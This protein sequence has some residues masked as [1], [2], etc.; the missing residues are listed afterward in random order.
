LFF[1]FPLKRLSTSFLTDLIKSF[2]CIIIWSNHNSMHRAFLFDEIIELLTPMSLREAMF[3][4]ILLSLQCSFI[5]NLN[6]LIWSSI[7]NQ[8]NLIYLWLLINLLKQDLYSLVTPSTLSLCS[9]DEIFEVIRGILKTCRL[10]DFFVRTIIIFVCYY[11]DF[12]RHN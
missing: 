3:R 2:S 12:Y 8:D 10:N 7:P 9:F 11:L 6:F 4:P 1:Q 5:K